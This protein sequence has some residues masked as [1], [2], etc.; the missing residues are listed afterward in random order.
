[1][2]KIVV[3]ILPQI[4]LNTDNNPYNDKY[5]FLDLYT[6]K[7]I[8]C[9][10][11]P[12]GIC[13]NNGKL[14]YSSLDICDAF[15]LPGGYK[16]DRCYYE[17]LFYCLKTNKPLLGICLGL[18]GMAIFSMVLDNVKD[19]SVESFIE[20]YKKLKEENDGTL[21]ARIPSPNIH[22]DLIIN[23][24]D[25]DDA[26]HEIKIIDKN[27]I[28]YDIYKKDKLNVVSLHSYNHNGLASHLKLLH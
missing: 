28:L 25:A 14:D 27:S 1:M 24:D 10:A 8:E 17:T 22:G 4:R 26:R 15:I 23:Y 16:V 20:T 2:K 3:G 19:N 21:L 6:R 13:L 12:I 9:G 11:I 5:E 18:E 7:I